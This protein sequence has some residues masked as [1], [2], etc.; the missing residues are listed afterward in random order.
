MSALQSGPESWPL[1]PA[2]AFF[3]R[4]V[5]I[6]A[7]FHSLFKTLVASRSFQR[8]RILGIPSLVTCNVLQGPGQPRLPGS[9]SN[10]D[11]RTF[12]RYNIPTHQPAT[13]PPLAVPEVALGKKRR[14]KRQRQL[15]MAVAAIR[16]RY[17]PQTLVRGKPPTAT[18]D[19]A[20]VPHIPTGFPP[21]DRALGIG[22]LPKGKISELVGPATSGKT[23][24][25]L[26]F[27]AQAQADGGQVGYIDQARYFDPDYAH[28]CD[29]DLSRLLVG[30]P[31]DLREALAM[32]E[33]LVRSGS[34]TALVFDADALDFLWTD[35][36]AAPQLAAFL[37]RLPA[38]L[39]RSRIAFLFLHES[40]TGRSPALRQALRQAQDE[41]QDVALSALA[42]YAA[43]RLQ[44]VRERWLRRHGDIRGYKARV[45]VLKNR[46]GPAGQAVTIAI[47]FDGTVRGNGL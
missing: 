3:F 35:P 7:L 9:P 22:G 39:A 28:R 2:K 36:G 20:V 32:T 5:Y 30:R 26:K 34:L 11:N 42:H 47:E 10:V 17:G 1:K 14:R 43:V 40:P 12:V 18:A 21:L 25:A 38:P 6:I 19:A 23:T 46:L 16:L 37:D 24:L 8:V 31:Y 29:L 13:A 4:Y 45:E 27:L 44:V 33:S 15:D 41:A